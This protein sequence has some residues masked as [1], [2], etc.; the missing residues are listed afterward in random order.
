MCTASRPSVRASTALTAGWIS[1]YHIKSV[2]TILE[3]E[4]LFYVNR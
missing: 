1:R 4:F 3:Q 2:T